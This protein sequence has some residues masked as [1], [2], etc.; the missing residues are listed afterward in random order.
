MNAEVIGQ[1]LRRLRGDKP[2]KD[3]AKALGISVSALTMYETGQRIPRDE[4]K[5]LLSRYYDYPVEKNFLQN[6]YT[7][8]KQNTSSVGQAGKGEKGVEKLTRHDFRESMLQV[9]FVL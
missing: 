4:I 7:K 1:K 9:L 5:I 8:C 6:K 2:R 3:V